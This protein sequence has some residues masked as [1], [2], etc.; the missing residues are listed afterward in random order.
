MTAVQTLAYPFFD[1][2]RTSSRQTERSCP[3]EL[4]DFTNEEIEAIGTSMPV[5]LGQ[6]CKRLDGW[7]NL[8]VPD[9]YDVDDTL[10]ADNFSAESTALGAPRDHFDDVKSSG[11]LDHDASAN[12]ASTRADLHERHRHIRSTALDGTLRV[13]GRYCGPGYHG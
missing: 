9:E 10:L 12:S 2:L 5:V 13:P 8:H 7:S 3:S 4:F 1:D 6:T 11:D